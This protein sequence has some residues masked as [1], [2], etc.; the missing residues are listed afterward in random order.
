MSSRELALAVRKGE[1]KA[2]CA[3]QREALAASVWPVE[4]ALAGADTLAAGVEWIKAR[5]GVV[6]A[7]VALAVIMRPRRVWRWGRRGLGLWGAW[8]ALKK[9]FLG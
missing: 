5:P 1:L 4:K 2:R 7:A 6:G 9:K 8:K 3:Q